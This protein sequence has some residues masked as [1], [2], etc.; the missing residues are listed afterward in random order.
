MFRPRS[1]PPARSSGPDAR[2]AA[3]DCLTDGVGLF[4]MLER[5]DEQLEPLRRSRLC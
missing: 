1:Q 2:P 3:A 5:L 4:R